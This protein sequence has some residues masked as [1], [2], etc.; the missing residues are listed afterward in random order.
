MAKPLGL[1]QAAAELGLGVQRLSELI[2]AGEV[3]AFRPGG[4]K[5]RY[6]I[7]PEEVARRKAATSTRRSA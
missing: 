7:D 1:K 2:R 3:V 4:D 6:Q 5:G